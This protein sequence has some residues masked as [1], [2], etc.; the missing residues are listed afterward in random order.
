MDDA[1]PEAS[2]QHFADLDLRLVKAVRGIRVLATVAWPAAVE[3]Q[4]LADLKRGHETLPR[5]DYVAPDF[6]PQRAEL[7]MIA[8]AADASHPLGAWLARSAASWAIAARMLEA[9]GTAGTTAPSIEL[10]GKPNDPLPGGGQTN[11]DAARWFLA[12]A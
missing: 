3:R 1:V 7:A 8:A 11:L 12:S 4:F 5:F 6:S 9:V 10:Y 2:V